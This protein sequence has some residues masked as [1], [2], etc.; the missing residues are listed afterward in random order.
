MEVGMT[1]G[2]EWDDG[3]KSRLRL[4]ASLPASG[5][6]SEAAGRRR[7]T[8]A[9]VADILERVLVEPRRPTLEG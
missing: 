4:P 9:L 6:S 1:D 2:A 7:Y 3:L 8:A 5:R